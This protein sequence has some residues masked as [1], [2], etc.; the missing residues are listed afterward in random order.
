MYAAQA[1]VGAFDP[2]KFAQR[3]RQKTRKTWWQRFMD[4]V[5]QRR[6]DIFHELVQY[7]LAHK[8]KD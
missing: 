4:S 2:V 1:R 8:P 6:A 3:I 5:E 7:R